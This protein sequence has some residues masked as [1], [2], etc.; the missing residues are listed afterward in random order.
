MKAAVFHKIGDIQ[1]DTVDDPRIEQSR[2]AI[3]RVTSTA[4]CGSDLHIYDGFIPQLKNEVLGHEFMG[5]VEDVGSEVTNLKKGDRVVVPFTV[6]CGKCYFC[7]KN[8]QMHC[9]N[10]NPEHYGPDGGLLTEK[11]GGLFGYTDLY[12]GY[13]GGQAEYV[14]VPYAD[15]GLHTVPES[16]KDEQVL[17][18][19]DIFPTGWSSIEWGELKGG[20]TVAIFG[21]GPVGL[22]A[23]K[24]AWIQGAA[25]VIAIDPVNYRLEKARRVNNVETLNPDEVDVIEAIRQMTNGRG[26]D[27]C[28]DAVGMEADRSLLEKAKAVINF[29]KGTPKVLEL[30]FQAVRRGGIVSVVGVY[31]T[32]FDNISIGR[33]FDKGITVR[34][35]QSFVH[36]NMNHLL[37][38]VV[39]GKVVLDD[40]ISHTLPLADA[41]KAYDMFKKKQD[42]CTKVVL[43]P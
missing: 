8:L 33:M 30:C 28:V 4:I 5:I 29:E 34:F 32:P 20:E 21:S 3:I 18:L 31:G 37:D 12:G 1:V 15:Y 10:S 27:L 38:L 22:M 16:L 19:T 40:I 2:D 6:A 9:E 13:N 35:G 43:K 25:R 17:F 39:Q 42:D 24:S 36:K 7:Q 26:A 41:S 23:Q 11:G 14:R